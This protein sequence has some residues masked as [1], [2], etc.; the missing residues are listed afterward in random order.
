MPPA[1]ANRGRCGLHSV[2]KSKHIR[3][4][5]MRPGV[6][7]ASGK[8]IGASPP[9]VGDISLKAV[10][11]RDANDRH[12]RVE[13]AVAAEVGQRIQRC[14][15]ARLGADSILRYHASWKWI[16]RKRIARCNETR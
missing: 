1:D 10:A 5:G 7:S 4:I 3:I 15:R 12:L 6:S 11:M 13:T 2:A 16:S 8:L 14:K 9:N